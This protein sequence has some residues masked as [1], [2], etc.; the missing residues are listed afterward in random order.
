MAHFWT[1]VTWLC[2]FVRAPVM[3]CLCVMRKGGGDVFWWWWWWNGLV[4]LLRRARGGLAQ[5]GCHLLNIFLPFRFSGVPN[6]FFIVSFF[7]LLRQFPIVS[8]VC[9][10]RSS[11]KFKG[12]DMA[13]FWKLFLFDSAIS[14]LHVR[15][16]EA[17]S[18]WTSPAGLR[19]KKIN[20]T[21]LRSQE[22][23][24]R[25]CKVWKTRTSLYWCVS[26]RLISSEVV[27]CAA[28]RMIQSRLAVARCCISSWRL[29][30]ARCSPSACMKATFNL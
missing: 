28:C 17:R 3:L 6:V 12:T 8:Q 11:T 26:S 1:P 2:V 10:E 24:S 5:Q 14:P 30:C 16:M 7:C 18:T 29:E 4:V 13:L 22:T 20:A 23:V 19:R 27:Y 25:G 21:Q 9:C 15:T